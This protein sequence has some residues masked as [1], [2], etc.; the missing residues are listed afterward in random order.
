MRHASEQNFLSV[1]PCSGRWHSEQ[2]GVIEVAM[3][4][5]LKDRMPRVVYQEFSYKSTG[6]FFQKDDVFINCS[7]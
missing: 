4:V 5:F 6:V 7:G 1:R 2:I 3:V